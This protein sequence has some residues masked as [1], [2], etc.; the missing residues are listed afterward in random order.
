MPLVCGAIML[1]LI[2]EMAKAGYSVA[3]NQEHRGA[4][5]REGGLMAPPHRPAGG[6]IGVGLFACNSFRE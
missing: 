4:V 2:E 3:A 5:W 6:D 1:A